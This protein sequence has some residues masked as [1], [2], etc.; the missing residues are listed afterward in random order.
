MSSPTAVGFGVAITM[1]LHFGLIG[2][3]VMATMQGEKKM[4]EELE[5]AMLRFEKVELLALGEEKPPEALPRIAN[6]EPAVRPPDE[7]NLAEPEEPVIDLQKEEPKEKEDIDARKRKM[8]DALSA[9]H[10][11]N[12]PTNEDTPEGSLE[13]IAGGDITDVAL[14]NLMNTYVAKLVGELSRYWEVPSTIPPEEIESLAGQVSVYVRLSEEGHVV[15]YRFLAESGNQ[16][17]NQSI[18]RLIRKFEV[19]AGRK[20]PLPDDPAVKDAVLRQGLNLQN[21]EYTGR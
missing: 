6:P 17:F 14:A 21:W 10:N 3:I 13:G 5:P 2:V 1:L 18:D 19:T 9:L 4:E 8:L 15:T 11:P 16:Q 20:L 7:I 12:R